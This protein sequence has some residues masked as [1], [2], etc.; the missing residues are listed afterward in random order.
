[1]NNLL[2]ILLAEDKGVVLLS[3]IADVASGKVQEDLVKCVLHIFDSIGE[4]MRLFEFIINKE[5]E[6]TSK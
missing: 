2:Q 4:S 3:A 5:V 6:K 1:M